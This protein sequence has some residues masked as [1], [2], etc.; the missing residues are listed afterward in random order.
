MHALVRQHR[1]ADDVADGVDV[2][3]IGSQLRIDGDEAALI[4]GDAG[5]FGGELLAVRRAADGDQHEVE[6]LAFVVAVGHLDAFG[7]AAAATTPVLSRMRS[8]RWAFFFSQTLTRSRSAP[9]ISTAPSSTT[10]MRE[11]SAE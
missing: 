5:L 1:L 7:V 11:P 9:G 4:D 2:R 6:A 8:K 3:D 10:V